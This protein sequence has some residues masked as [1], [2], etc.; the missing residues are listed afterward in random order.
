M[1]NAVDGN[2]PARRLACPA[3]QPVVNGKHKKRV[4]AATHFIMFVS[5]SP[6]NGNDRARQY[7][8]E[9]DNTGI[10]GKN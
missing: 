3:R 8:N 6:V 7:K 2:I 10:N 5:T 9:N 1:A 4:S